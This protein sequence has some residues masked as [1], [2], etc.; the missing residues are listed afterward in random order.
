[1]ER[2]WRKANSRESEIHLNDLAHFPL[3]E[4]CTLRVPLLLSS[5]ERA[6]NTS[7][8]RLSCLWRGC[9]GPHAAAASNRTGADRARPCPA[10]QPLFARHLTGLARA[11]GSEA[12]FR[13]RRESERATR[14]HAPGSLGGL[15][16]T[17][18]TDGPIDLVM[19]LQVGVVRAPRG[20][21]PAH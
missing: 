15:G 20:L 10:K 17:I 21:R 3:W 1:L 6:K 18:V 5:L 4:H 2:I 16:R 7:A 9:G 19:P 8:A 11:F 13:Q 14:G 12:C